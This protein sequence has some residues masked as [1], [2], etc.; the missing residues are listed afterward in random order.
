MNIRWLSSALVELDRIHG[1]IAWE[2]PKAAARVFRQIR[3]APLQ[4]ARFPQLGRPSQVEGTRELVVAGLPY[5]IVYRVAGDDVEI[6]RVVH[7]SMN[8]I[9][10]KM[11]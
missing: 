7:M 9:A 2:N 8:W 6:L 10:D 1:Y 4:L 3:K 11:Q 5:L